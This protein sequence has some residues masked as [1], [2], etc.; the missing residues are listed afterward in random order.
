QPPSGERPPGHARGVGSGERPS[1]ARE[2]VLDDVDLE[3]AAFAWTE[4]A[5][6]MQR[7]Q[8]ST[9][10]HRS[11]EVRVVQG[12]LASHVA[13]DVAFAAQLARQT[14]RA[15]EV[16]PVGFPDDDAGTWHLA[17]VAESDREGWQLPV[18][19]QTS[20]AFGESAGSRR[21]RIRRMRKGKALRPEHAL[22]AVVVRL[23]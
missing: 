3:A 5:H 14:H 21:R 20:G 19:S 18:Q 11:R 12:V 2:I 23:E 4:R 15:V 6:L 17:G 13:S 1:L 9:T 22:D 8:F 16:R 10:A 7:A